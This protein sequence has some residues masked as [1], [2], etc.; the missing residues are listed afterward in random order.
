V[1]EDLRD[2]GTVSWKQVRSAEPSHVQPPPHPAA[3]TSD[4]VTLRIA[5]VGPLA[6]LQR[7]DVA[8]KIM[9]TRLRLSLGAGAPALDG[10]FEARVNTDGS[11]W[12]FEEPS[13]AGAAR[14]L[15]VTLEKLQPRDDWEYMYDIEVSQV[16][17]KVT[18]EAFFDIS[19]DDRYAG[20]IVFGLFGS[21]VPR[22][23]A[24]FAELCTGA[25]GVSEISGAPLHYKGSAFHRCIPG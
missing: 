10:E 1:R 13:V 23:A 25:R 9:P 2:P 21:D 24:N 14:V 22:T 15:I 18:Q 7:A 11:F 3:Q 12:Q 19:I 8:C 16:D 4:D 5:L 6:A 20:R 17:A